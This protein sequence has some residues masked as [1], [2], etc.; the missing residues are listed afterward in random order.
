MSRGHLP[1]ETWSF[2][3]IPTISTILGGAK[4][5][6]AAVGT[7][8]SAIMDIT[9]LISGESI[10]NDSGGEVLVTF[11]ANLSAVSMV[12]TWFY[13]DVVSYLASVANLCPVREMATLSL[14]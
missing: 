14:R 9:S 10:I 6:D 3:C 7:A 12:T 1:T 8:R 11:D 4:L 2:M 5:N 13:A